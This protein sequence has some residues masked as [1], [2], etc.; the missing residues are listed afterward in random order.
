MLAGG[1]QEVDLQ[2]NNNLEIDEMAKFAVAEHNDR[3]NSL[4]KLTFSKVVSC[5]T[6]VVAGTMYHLVIEV[7]E[8]SSI[9]P[10]EARVW[11]KPWQNFKKL[12]E[13]KLKDAGVTSADLGVR[14]GGPH[15][16]GRG[17]NA[18]PSGKQSWPTDDPAV[19]EAAEHA[20]KMLQQGSN[21]LASYELSEIV[22]ADAELSDESADF[23]LLLKIKRGAKEEHFKSEIHR[24]GDGD[25]SV[26]HVTLQ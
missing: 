16:T 18:P 19:Q 7:E 21:S 5:H 15:S 25:W 17:I 9:K 10:Y 1:K 12:E 3:E 6:Q 4:E 20:M 24:T 22:S 2:N 13:F 8:G 11:V 26:K 23:E 14:T